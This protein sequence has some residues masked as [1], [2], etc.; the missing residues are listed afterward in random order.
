MKNEKVNTVP[1]FEFQVSSFKFLVQACCLYAFG[2]SEFVI[3]EIPVDDLGD[4]Y[5]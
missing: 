1:G 4:S 3:A 2:F 5:R